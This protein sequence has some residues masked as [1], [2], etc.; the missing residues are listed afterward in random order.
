MAAR[1]CVCVSIHLNLTLPS[2]EPCAFFNTVMPLFLHG[3]ATDPKLQALFSLYLLIL[4]WVHTQVGAHPANVCDF[5]FHFTTA[6]HFPNW[7][8]L[9]RLRKNWHVARFLFLSRSKNKTKN[10]FTITKPASINCN[11]VWMTRSVCGIVVYCWNNLTSSLTLTWVRT[12]QCRDML[13]VFA[14]C[15]LFH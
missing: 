7:Q 15:E 11:K 6:L 5:I 12:L 1:L 2:N 3:V 14:I 4:F 10:S 8:S 13:S 9:P